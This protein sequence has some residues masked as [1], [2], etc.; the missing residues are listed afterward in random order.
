MLADED[1][2]EVEFGDLRDVFDHIGDPV[3]QFSKGGHVPW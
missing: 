3:E 1:W 2:V